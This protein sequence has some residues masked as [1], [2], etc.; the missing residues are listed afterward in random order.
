MK[1]TIQMGEKK[2]DFDDGEGSNTFMEYA[3][4]SISDL[5]K[6]VFSEEM[7]GQRLVVLPEE[8]AN[9][10]LNDMENEFDDEEEEHL[11]EEHKHLGKKHDNGKD[12][13]GPQVN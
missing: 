6:S 11:C 5:L 1:I 10:L 13:L 2:Y 3:I 12:K 4:D 7:E 8:L 9:S